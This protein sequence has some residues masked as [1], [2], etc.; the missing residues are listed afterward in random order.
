[1]VDDVGCN[2]QEHLESD[3]ADHLAHLAEIGALGQVGACE[4]VLYQSSANVVSP[5][6][7]R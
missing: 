2:V 5:E 3:L 7:Q 4:E 1:M 6:G